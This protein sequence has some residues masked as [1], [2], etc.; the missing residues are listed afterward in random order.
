MSS[1][2]G[3]KLLPFPGFPFW[4]IFYCPCWLGQMA[5]AEPQLPR[6]LEAGLTVEEPTAG[7]IVT[8]RRCDSAW[9]LDKAGVWHRLQQANVRMSGAERLMHYTEGLANDKLDAEAAAEDT[10]FEKPFTKEQ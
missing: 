6:H 4:R 10:V 9:Y 1:S 7:Q 2:P 3:P 8:C 5:D